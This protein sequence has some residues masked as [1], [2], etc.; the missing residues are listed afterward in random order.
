MCMSD[1]HPPSEATTAEEAMLQALPNGEEDAEG[2]DIAAESAY[3]PSDA[4]RADGDQWLDERR[5]ADADHHRRGHD[6]TG[7]PSSPP[8]EEGL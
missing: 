7:R 2:G 4:V 3:T 6:L 1:A 8:Q 5:E